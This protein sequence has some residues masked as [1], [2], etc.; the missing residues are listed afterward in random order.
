MPIASWTLR[1]IRLQP[2]PNGAGCGRCRRDLAL[3]QFH[4]QLQRV[5]QV[6]YASLNP[7]LTVEDSIACGPM[8]HGVP[9]REALGRAHDLQH[10]VGLAPGRFAG[11]YPHR[12]SGG[13]RQRINIAG[14]LALQTRL[15]ILDEAVS[16][17]E[18]GGQRSPD[19]HAGGEP[20]M[21]ARS[22][23]K[24]RIRAPAAQWAVR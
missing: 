2:G 23:C 24:A 9:R 15:V 6:S 19:V 10:R 5:F 4:R 21:S 8:V 3:K 14:L 20:G 18:R 11:R 22:R 17:L 12:L 16:A 13:Q 7:R 1:G